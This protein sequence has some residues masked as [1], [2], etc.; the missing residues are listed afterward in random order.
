MIKDEEIFDVI[1]DNQYLL[2]LISR[3]IGD[4]EESEYYGNYNF[5]YHE[6]EI[7]AINFFTENDNNERYSI[8]RF[9]DDGRRS[10]VSYSRKDYGINSDNSNILQLVKSIILNYLRRE[11][12]KTIK[13]KLNYEIT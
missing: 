6:N 13:N 10:T 4:D 11:K 7:F 8:I 1:K 5:T 9:F 12:I 3:T 2:N